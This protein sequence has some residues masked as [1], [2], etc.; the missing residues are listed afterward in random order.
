MHAH[1]SI[2]IGK[3]M[4]MLIHKGLSPMWYCVL[5][6][7]SLCRLTEFLSFDNPHKGHNMPEPVKTMDLDNNGRH[8]ER[9]RVVQ[10]APT[11]PSGIS[12]STRSSSKPTVYSVISS[13]WSLFAPRAA[14]GPSVHWRHF[15]RAAAAAS[16]AASSDSTGAPIDGAAGWSQISAGGL[17]KRRGHVDSDDTNI[18]EDN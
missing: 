17:H 2:S 4:F 8:G 12:C 18:G 7:L 9:S 11:T 5:T 16:H 1:Q 13:M 14:Y 15:W 10:N 3:P 6:N